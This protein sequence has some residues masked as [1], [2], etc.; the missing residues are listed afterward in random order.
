MYMKAGQS[1]HG[2]FVHHLS[3]ETD[4]LRYQV[5]LD[6]HKRKFLTSNYPTSESAKA[7]AQAFHVKATA[8]LAEF[9]SFKGKAAMCMR[10]WIW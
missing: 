6:A 1:N 3:L 7:A 5:R 10:H 8:M 9:D 2:C 4:W